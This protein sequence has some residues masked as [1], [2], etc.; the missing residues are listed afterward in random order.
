M[1]EMLTNAEIRKLKGIYKRIT[2]ACEKKG[3]KNIA[4]LNAE[5]TKKRGIGPGRSL[6]SKLRKAA[7]PDEDYYNITSQNLLVIADAL[8]VSVDYLLGRQEEEPD[9]NNVLTNLGLSEKS[10]QNLKRMHEGALNKKT[11]KNLETNST[12]YRTPDQKQLDA[13]NL[14]LEHVNTDN[15]GDDYGNYDFLTTVYQLVKLRLTDKGT[16]SFLVSEDVEKTIDEDRNMYLEALKKASDDNG[17]KTLS[18]K[19]KKFLISDP[20]CQSKKKFLRFFEQGIMSYSDPLTNDDVNVCMSDPKKMQ[21]ERII[22]ILNEWRDEY[23]QEREKFESKDRDDFDK[24]VKRIT[25]EMKKEENQDEGDQENDAYVPDWLMYRDPF[26]RDFSESQMKKYLAYLVLEKHPY[27]DGNLY[28][29]EDGIVI[30]IDDD[31]ENGLPAFS[32]LVDDD[33]KKAGFFKSEKDG[34]VHYDESVAESTRSRCMEMFKRSGLITSL[35][36]YMQHPVGEMI[37]NG[38][39]RETDKIYSGETAQ[40]VIQEASNMG[41]HYRVD[42]NMLRIWKDEKKN[43][44][45]DL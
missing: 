39:Y 6:Y 18:G 41:I 1:P 2:D 32:L 37:F 14:I 21:E 35:K 36:K 22:S 23:S 10:A 25:A 28:I 30:T 17:D 3:Y 29:D 11:R 9:Q 26:L 42:G 5:I 12:Y 44:N 31:G 8:D 33:M 24:W 20:V 16:L 4:E 38:Y 19:R 40:E 7:E 27:E 45:N 43:K 15:N 34:L 13:L